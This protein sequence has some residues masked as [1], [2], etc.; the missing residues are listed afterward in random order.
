MGNVLELV[1][2]AL[3]VGGFLAATAGD[4]DD[5][6]NNQEAERE[7]E[8]QAKLMEEQKNYYE[9]LNKKNQEKIDDLEKMLKENLD[10]IKRKDLEREK[11][12]IEKEKKEE[13]KR[14]QE[15]EN[16][17]IAIKNCK[18]SLNNVLSKGLFKII[19]KF[20]IE[21][22]KWLDQ[23]NEPKIQNK[24]TNLKQKLESLFEELFQNEKI[25]S[26]INNKFVNTIQTS[27][28]KK[29]LEKMNFIAIGTSGVEK[30]H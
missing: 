13:E 12:L 28:N 17:K 8:R 14:I 22:Q 21:E 5:N 15:L 26:E 24:I 20:K 2:I 25:I 30:V 29:E 7:L 1:P 18:R 3:G 11:E 23:I 4:G 6:A 27:V 19:G 9:E 10:E 16:M